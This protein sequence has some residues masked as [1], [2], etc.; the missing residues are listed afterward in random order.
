MMKLFYFAWLRTKIGTAE[1]RVEPPAFVNSLVPTEGYVV[2]R[3]IAYGAGPRRKLDVYTPTAVTAAGQA[4]PVVV[5]FYGGAW[6]QGSREDYL[7]LGQALTEK[8]FDAVVPDYRLSP[9]G[10]YPAFLD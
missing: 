2:A 5:F 4:A 1:E 6:Y 7:F 9:E 3:D 10:V 8:G